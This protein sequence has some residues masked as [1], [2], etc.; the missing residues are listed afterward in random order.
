MLK[1]I[2]GIKIGDRVK[3]RAPYGDHGHRTVTRKVTA[4]HFLHE[5]VEVSSLFG[6]KGYLVSSYEIKEVNG[7]AV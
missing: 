7:K 5:M 2:Y 1:N 4:I 3:F 6:L